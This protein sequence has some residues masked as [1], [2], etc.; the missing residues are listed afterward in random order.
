MLLLE[1]AQSPTTYPS[2][3]EALVV[4]EF[5]VIS[6]CVILP[7]E[8]EYPR[9][10]LV[11]WRGIA[12]TPA[13]LPCCHGFHQPRE[14]VAGAIENFNSPNVRHDDSFA[15]DKCYGGFYPVGVH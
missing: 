12:A 6:I 5:L 9:C 4:L 15:V 7:N 1:Y 2:G 8:W 10:R 13:K 3:D 14:S 11:S